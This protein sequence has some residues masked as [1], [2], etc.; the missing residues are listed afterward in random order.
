MKIC[1]ITYEFIDDNQNYS[2]K[3]LKLLSPKL[4]TLHPL[5]F[6]SA[7][8]LRECARRAIKISIQ[9]VQPKLS[10]NLSVIDARFELAD[11]FARYILKPQHNLYPEVPQNEDL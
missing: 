9:G 5:A 11:R 4:K 8:L 10:A 2:S 3:G 6:T 7:E 1:P